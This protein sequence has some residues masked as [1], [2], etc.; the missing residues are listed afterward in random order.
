MLL[1][2]GQKGHRDERTYAVKAA[3]PTAWP[4]IG[5]DLDN[6]IIDY[7]ELI[8]SEVR[9]LGL[10]ANV[11]EGGKRALRDALRE[12]P[13]GEEHWVRLQARIYGPRVREAVA[14]PGVL[15]F[16]RRARSAGIDVAIVSHKTEIPAAGEQHDLR[17]GARA[18]LEASG[19]VAPDAVGAGEVYFESTREAK[20]RRIA[21]LGLAAFVDDLHEVFTEPAFPA[22]VQRWLFAPGGAGEAPGADRVFVSWRAIEEH[23]FRGA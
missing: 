4:R 18:W 3:N 22:G 10:M 11:P 16:V 7:E 14:F 19:I 9:A 13:D 17:A 23:V 5:I 15:S 8:R 21:S 1:A 6:T 20:L 12:L 2:I